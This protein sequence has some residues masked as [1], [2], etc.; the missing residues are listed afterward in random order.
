MGATNS[1]EWNAEG[2]SKVE[3]EGAR[4]NKS[5]YDG[6]IKS[7]RK[8]QPIAED[9]D[10]GARGFNGSDDSHFDETAVRAIGGGVVDRIDEE[11]LNL[12][13]SGDQNERR[14]QNWEKVTAADGQNLEIVS[15]AGVVNAVAGG[16]V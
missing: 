7:S 1:R 10:V 16:D 4:K 13:E 6:K 14:E 11:K 5:K 9:G 12:V 8:L 15:A 2:E 3:E